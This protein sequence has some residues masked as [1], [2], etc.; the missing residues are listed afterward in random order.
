MTLL[1]MSR[2]DE[3]ATYR[4]VTACRGALLLGTDPKA[5]ARDAAQQHGVRPA[6]VIELAKRAHTACMHARQLARA[7][8]DAPDP[9]D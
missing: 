5:A 2:S 4:A 8:R 3:L 9:D 6:L 1:P 7:R